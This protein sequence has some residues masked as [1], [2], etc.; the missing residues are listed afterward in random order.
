MNHQDS[1]RRCGTDGEQARTNKQIARILRGCGR[2][3]AVEKDC[4]AWRLGGGEFTGRKHPFCRSSMDGPR[5]LIGESYPAL[6]PAGRRSF[7]L[8]SFLEESHQESI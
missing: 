1:H 8:Y 7:G 5:V 6:L 4:P 2:R 3:R